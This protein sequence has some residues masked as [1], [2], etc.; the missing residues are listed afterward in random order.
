MTSRTPAT[1]YRRL[2]V[3]VIIA[4][5]L[6]LSYVTLLGAPG[7]QGNDFPLLMWLAYATRW[8]DWAPSAIGHY[9][10]AQPLL[11]RWLMPVFGSS[12]LAVKALNW[13]ASLALLLAIV[14]VVRQRT[15][16]GWA[17]WVALVGLVSTTSF[18]LTAVSEFADPLSA[19]CYFW[20]FVLLAQAMIESPPALRKV[21]IGSVVLGMSGIFRIHYQYFALISP[22]ILWGAHGCRK[23]H[24]RVCGVALV[25][26]C[27]AL[28][29]NI[30]LYMGV[31]GQPTSPVATY[32]LGQVLRGIQHHDFLGTYA[33]ITT[34]EVLVSHYDVV[35]RLLLTRCAEEPIPLV[36]ALLFTLLGVA[37]RRRHPGDAHILW[38]LAALII[39]YFLA[40][41]APGYEIGFRHLLPLAAF[42]AVGVALVLSRHVS[43]Q[44]L[45]GV[46]NVALVVLTI[47]GGLATH[48]KLRPGN[49]QWE[50][51]RRLTASLRT[52]GMQEP[53]EA[54][55]F[56]WDRF[57]V[58]EPQLIS[59]YNFGWWN[60]VNPTYRQ[61]RPVPTLQELRDPE[62]FGAFAVK[63]H[64][65]FIVFDP[66]IRRYAGLLEVVSGTRT[67]PGFHFLVRLGTDIVFAADD[68]SQ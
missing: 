12:V 44:V 48:T 34:R 4:T 14:H 43:S 56:S 6:V 35:I 28:L 8:D 62:A 15:S 40:F 36:A 33:Q 61:A 9:G 30:V 51:S 11:V 10:F 37:A 31:Y 59:F 53:G 18:Q 17:A 50:A 64:I 1:L 57:P 5:M 65:R 55:V 32:F 38:S 58:D 22:V 23:A 27:V 47:S 16:D 45:R 2:T 13:V 7:L 66:T 20:G 41:V 19:A 52:A 29:P 3:A 42:S 26:A 60:L 39:V 21:F 68:V 49:A 24:L 25:G 54:F 63:N 46:T 67:L